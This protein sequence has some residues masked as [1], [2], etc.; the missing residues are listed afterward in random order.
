MSDSHD[1]VAP[2]VR[3]RVVAGESGIS[4]ATLY[5]AFP[6]GRDTIVAAVL[7]AELDRLSDAIESEVAAASDL[8][9]ALARTLRVATVWLTANEAIAT[10]MFDEPAVLLT[11]LE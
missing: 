11:H 2:S 1:A 8:R 9:G 10:L 7:D 3:E 6:G 4:R 5:R